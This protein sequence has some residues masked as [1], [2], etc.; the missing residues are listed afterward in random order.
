MAPLPTTSFRK[1]TAGQGRPSAGMVTSMCLRLLK[2]K[3]IDAYTSAD[4]IPFNI[5]V[6]TTVIGRRPSAGITGDARK[7]ATPEKTTA[8]GTGISPT[9][10]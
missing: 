9:P 6:A 1:D 5:A 10:I 3:G 4:Q 2:G 7:A 8:T